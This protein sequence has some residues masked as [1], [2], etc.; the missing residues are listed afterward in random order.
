LLGNRRSFL[1]HGDALGKVMLV[2]GQVME[3]YFA[4]VNVQTTAMDL[5]WSTGKRRD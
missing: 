2:H 4:K 1:A 3:A 5:V